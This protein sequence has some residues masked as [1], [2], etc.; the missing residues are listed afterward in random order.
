MTRRL[1]VTAPSAAHVLLLRATVLD[2][3]AG[4]SAYRQWIARHD[5]T[6]LDE[7]SYELLPALF[8]NLERLG[9][10]DEH[11]GRLRGIWRHAWVGN[12]KLFFAASDALAALAQAGIPTMLLKGSALVA[13]G[14]AADTGARPMADVDVL[15][16]YD[17]GPAAHRVLVAAGWQMLKPRAFGVAY[18]VGHSEPFADAQGRE[19]DLHWEALFDP[20]P[21]AGLWQRARPATL[22]HQPT[23][24]PSPADQ[25][26]ITCLHAVGWHGKPIRWLADAAV[27]LSRYED[28]LVWDDVVLEARGRRAAHRMASQ[29]EL[30]AELLGCPVPARVIT[31]LRAEPLPL[32]ERVMQ[33]ATELP[34]GGARVF[35]IS[36]DHS[37][38]AAQLPVPRREPALAWALA[39][40]R[41]SSVRELAATYVRR[42]ARRARGLPPTP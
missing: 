14:S 39:E 5:L 3:D 32:V 26:I 20:G 19:F 17:A 42:A 9:V 25:L 33:R 13:D 12:N 30:V 18:A 28:E 7:H 41:A 8:R 10:E 29:L 27:L 1:G 21:D 24:I 22:R 40:Y 31:Q 35:L 34:H 15:V 6:L 2:G 4:R 16:P 38:R 37:R 23:S 11:T 36:W